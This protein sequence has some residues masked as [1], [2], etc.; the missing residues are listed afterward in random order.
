MAA[1]DN[2]HPNQMKMFMRP[3]EIIDSVIGSVDYG[4]YDVQGGMGRRRWSPC[5]RATCCA[6]PAGGPKTDHR[7]L[8]DIHLRLGQ[9]RGRQGT[10]HPHAW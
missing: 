10:G 4:S 5:C 6:N 8:Q 3:G 7:G 2:V 1:S 9:E